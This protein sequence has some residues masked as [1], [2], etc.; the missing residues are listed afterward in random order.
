ME[1]KGVRDIYFGTG[2]YNPSTRDGKKLLAHELTHVVQQGGSSTIQQTDSTGQVGDAFEQEADQA[3][4]L[5][6]RG[7][8]VRVNKQGAAPAYQRNQGAAPQPAQTPPRTF[9]VPTIDVT[10]DPHGA[11][12]NG[13]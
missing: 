7:A 10:T 11:L 12:P 9:P 4:E 3:A 8:Q 2:E 5:V 1:R 13:I 6:A